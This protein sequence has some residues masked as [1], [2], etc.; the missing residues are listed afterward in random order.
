MG[1][2]IFL[3]YINQKDKTIF[4]N[5]NHSCSAILGFHMSNQKKGLHFPSLLYL[6]TPYGVPPL[7]GHSQVIRS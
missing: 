2:T 6:S 4:K 1:G 7:D 3:A 5:K